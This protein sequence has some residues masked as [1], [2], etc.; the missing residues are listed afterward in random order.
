MAG[1]QTA[2][3]ARIYLAYN[4]KGAPLW[5]TRADSAERARDLAVTSTDM[6]WET[7]ERDGYA[8]W[9]TWALPKGRRFPPSASQE[10]GGQ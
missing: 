8:V 3:N 10:G 5:H 6:E 1:E 9:E 2:R 7:L 4:P